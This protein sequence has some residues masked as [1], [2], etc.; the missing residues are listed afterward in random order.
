MSLF[1][2]NPKLYTFDDED[3]QDIESSNILA[4]KYCQKTY[5]LSVKFENGGVYI[6]SS[7]PPSIYRSFCIAE[8]KGRF[9]F[10][11][12]RGSYP[13]KRITINE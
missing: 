5:T 2:L 12:I 4:A 11:K 7:L 1:N 13:Y 10:K 6:Y 8:S 9:L 3:T